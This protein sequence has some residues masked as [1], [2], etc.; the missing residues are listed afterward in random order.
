MSAV[1][2]DK[3][4]AVH[5]AHELIL[6]NKVFL[7]ALSFRKFYV[8]GNAETRDTLLK[9]GCMGAGSCG[10]VCQNGF[11]CVSSVCSNTNFGK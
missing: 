2:A 11:S 5:L 10:F 8:L 9:C 7:P 3:N 1:P 6:C 4:A